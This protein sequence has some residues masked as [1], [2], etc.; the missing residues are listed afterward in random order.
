M[1]QHMR[2][3]V[4]I[5]LVRAGPM[6]HHRLIEALLKLAPQP[7]NPPLRFLRKFLLRRAILNRPHR[8]PHLKLEVLHQRRQLRLQF[9]RPVAQLHIA[10]ARQLRPLLV[11]R[12]LLLARRLALLFQLRQLAMHLVE[13]PRNIHLLRAQPL[14]APPQ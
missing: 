10:L 6:R 12:I 7:L 14:R 4:R 5:P 11:Q 13:E 1:L 8:L 3:R 9:P 2:L